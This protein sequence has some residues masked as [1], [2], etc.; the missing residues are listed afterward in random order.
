MVTDSASRLEHTKSIAVTMVCPMCRARW[1]LGR[2]G[3]KG[4]EIID[5]EALEAAGWT[6]APQAALEIGK[7]P[8]CT[9]CGMVGHLASEPPAPAGENCRAALAKPPRNRDS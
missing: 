2:D 3:M 9:R 1:T 6:R 8:A 5:E 7:V 4:A